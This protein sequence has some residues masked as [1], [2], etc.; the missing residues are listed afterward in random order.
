V[1]AKVN[2]PG[3]GDRAAAR[4]HDVSDQALMQRVCMADEPAY[5]Q[6]VNRHLSGVLA[7]ARRILRDDAEAED[8][9][10]EVMLRLWRQAAGLE[11]GPGGIGAWLR[12]VAFN[13]SIDRIRSGRR[14][15]V[16]DEVPEQV[17]EAGQLTGLAAAELGTR[18]DQALKA[19]PERQRLAL[20][21]FH[22][23][24][25]SQV[26]VGQ[27]LG[28]SDEAVESLLARARRALKVDLQADWRQ[29]LED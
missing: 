15:D 7:T 12:R 5:R 20:T 13:L 27:K 26:E 3:P 22:F 6:L 28:V 2:E 9:A 1:A 21:L 18:V 11:V 17:E 16:T 23:E 19:L 25:L 4:G 14:T 24:G 10:Q 29:L 8:V